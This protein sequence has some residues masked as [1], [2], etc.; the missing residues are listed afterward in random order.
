MDVNDESTVFEAVLSPD[1][2]KKMGENEVLIGLKSYANGKYLSAK[3][4]KKET[5][6]ASEDFLGESEKFYVYYGLHNVIGLKAKINGK[7]IVANPSKNKPLYADRSKMQ[8][9]EMF[10]VVPY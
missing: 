6:V 3:N 1:S 8:E 4:V 9:W 10:E 5:L 7:F 2:K